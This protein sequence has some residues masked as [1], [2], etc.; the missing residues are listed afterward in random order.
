MGND[1][2]YEYSTHEDRDDTSI[3]ISLDPSWRRWQRVPLANRGLNR[4]AGRTDKVTELITGTDDKRSEAA[5]R[6]FHEMDGNDTPRS[7]DSEL[8]EESSRDDRVIAEESVRVDESSAEETHH[9]DHE[10]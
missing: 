4:A 1:G 2:T 5:G 10:A 8:L 6:Q 3:V 9:D 7:L